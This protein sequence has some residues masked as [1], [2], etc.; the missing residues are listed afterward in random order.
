MNEFEIYVKYMRI[1]IDTYDRLPD[2]FSAELKILNCI[3]GQANKK[4]TEAQLELMGFN[5]I[6]FVID[7]NKKNVG[8]FK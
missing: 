1:F 3:V 5:D 7:E 4:F 6:I 2:K 8:E